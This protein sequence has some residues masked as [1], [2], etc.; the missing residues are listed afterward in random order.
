MSMKKNKMMRLASA[1]LVLTLLTTSVISG[2]FA[3]YTTSA[4]A[5]DTARVAKWGVTVS[6]SG[7]LFGSN[8][9]NKD[10]GNTPI[11]GTTNISVEGKNSSNA[12]EVVAPGTQ[13]NASGFA[14]GITGTPEVSSKVSATIT[15][16][17]IYLA[18]GTYGVM[19]Q[20]TVNATNY[21][22]LQA[23]G[24]YTENSGAYTKV[25][26][27]T[28]SDRTYYALAYTV[29]LESAYYPVVYSWYANGSSTATANT[30]SATAIAD[31]IA[32]KFNSSATDNNTTSTAVATYSVSKSVAPNI[33]LTTTDGVAIKAEKL[34]WEWKFEDG[35][36]SQD[37]ILGDLMA[38]GT[39]NTNVVAVES[40]GAVTVLTVTDNIVKNGENEVGCLETKFDI[41]LT[42]E[43]AD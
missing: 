15:A 7:S 2:T 34:T 40:D 16:Q 41:S 14:F 42:V 24:L 43:Q 11:V 3:K 26:S 27:T 39:G 22:S 12:A 32:K 21:A 8:Y 37:T 29:K 38:A 35:K 23:K 13:S 33:D 5:S 18:A 17:D 4:S 36:D 31:A 30:T 28:Y 20:V 6:A 1:L 10:N 25:T 9:A 19:E